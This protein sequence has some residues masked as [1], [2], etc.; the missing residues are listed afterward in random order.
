M[1]SFP[2]FR[3]LLFLSILLLA[4]PHGASAHA[5]I[6]SSQPTAGA[7]IGKD[8]VAIRLRFNSRID[9]ARSRLKLLAPDG[10]EQALT[11]AADTPA[12][13]LNAD[14]KSL[15]PGAWR[16]HWQVL[17]VDGHITRGDIPFTVR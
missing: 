11:P 3:H 7:T 10:A 5:I 2:R 6:V 1:H 8:A 9:H 16:L 4:A 17:S 12:D 13:E 15:A 14:A